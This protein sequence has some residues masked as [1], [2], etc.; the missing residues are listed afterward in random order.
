MAGATEYEAV[1]RY[2]ESLRRSISCVVRDAFLD[3]KGRYYVS[4]T[5]H[6]ITLDRGLP[7]DL[8]GGDLS[9]AVTQHYRLIEKPSSA[10]PWQ[11]STVAYFYALRDADGQEILAY[12]WHPRVTPEVTFPHLHVGYGARVERPEFHRAHLPTGR[13]ALEDFVRALIEDFGVSPVRENW[14]DVLAKSRAEFE[15][16]RSW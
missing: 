3:V 1:E 11:V 6:P 7:V 2:R 16:D 10:E 8:A 15:A 5:P 12:H 4:A 13:V 9:V 14:T